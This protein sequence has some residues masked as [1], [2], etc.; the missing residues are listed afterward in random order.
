MCVFF[1]CFFF[2]FCVTGRETGQNI[3]ANLARG[4][5][6]KR[7]GNGVQLWRFKAFLYPFEDLTCALDFR[8]LR[9]FLCVRRLSMYGPN[10]VPNS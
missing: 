8:K 7:E 9:C 10:F 4:R 2:V 5:L 1:V 3:S 6:L